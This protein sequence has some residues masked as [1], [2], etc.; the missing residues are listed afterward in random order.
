MKKTRSRKSR[1]T[2]PLN[3]RI[4]NIM[5]Y[6]GFELFLRIGIVHFRVV[7]LGGK[8][9]ETS[10]NRKYLKNKSCCENNNKNIKYLYSTVL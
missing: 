6:F 2:V 8:V 10:K 1:D 9:L 7:G 5:I 3:T 4:V